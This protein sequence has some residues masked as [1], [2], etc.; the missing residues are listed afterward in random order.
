MK[1]SDEEL[2]FIVAD[3]SPRKLPD[4][5]FGFKVRVL[6]FKIFTVYTHLANGEDHG[7]DFLIDTFGNAEKMFKKRF[8]NREIDRV[9]V[10][11]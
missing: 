3:H 4:P 8:P 6:G 10:W 7:V 2:K 1:L 9:G 5:L 11:P